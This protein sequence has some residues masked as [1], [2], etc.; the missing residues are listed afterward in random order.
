M[1]GI[2]PERVIREGNPAQQ[3]LEAID[4]D[5][6]IS[7]LVLGASA[8][9]EGPGPIVTT[10]AKTAGAFPIPIVVVPGT[11]SDEE[12]RRP[13]VRAAAGPCASRKPALAGVFSAVIC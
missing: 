3:I 9:A 8:G 1:A 13:V 6:D 5:V 4:A 7:M 11:L 10:T 12:Y 2:T